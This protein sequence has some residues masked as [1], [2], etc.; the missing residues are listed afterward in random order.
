MDATRAAGISG[1]GGI[2]ILS[3]ARVLALD[4]GG[5]H[6]RIGTVLRGPDSLR[7]GGNEI[8]KNGYWTRTRSEREMMP[9][10]IFVTD[11]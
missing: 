7:V 5:I 3:G 6:G 11:M 1:V 8:D 2:R 9:L 10:V 4:L